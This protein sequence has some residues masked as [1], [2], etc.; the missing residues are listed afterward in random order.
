[1]I[2]SELFLAITFD[3]FCIYFEM[4]I[5]WILP[6]SRKRSIKC[7]FYDIVEASIKSA[8]KSNMVDERERLRKKA[9][10]WERVNGQAKE[11]WAVMNA[12]DAT[13]NLGFCLAPTFYDTKMKCVLM[14]TDARMANIGKY[15]V[16]QF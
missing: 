3:S 2:W 12:Q 11:W 6:K 14:E 1:M 16:D 9:S 15:P 7:I 4:E 13:I 5:L 8:R 10:K